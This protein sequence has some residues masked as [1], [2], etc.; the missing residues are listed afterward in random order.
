MLKALKYL[1]TY[2]LWLINE[3][4]TLGL[5]VTFKNTRQLQFR[6]LYNL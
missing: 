6:S 2:I 5:K 4:S 3:Q 1:N